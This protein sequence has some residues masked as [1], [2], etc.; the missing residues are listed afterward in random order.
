MFYIIQLLVFKLVVN[1]VVI[2]VCA[3]VSLFTATRAAMMLTGISELSLVLVN[4]A[5]SLGLVTRE[6]YL[7]I[8]SSTVIAMVSGNEVR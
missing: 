3:H 8:L 7:Q 6:V 1:A 4:R 5:E 2:K